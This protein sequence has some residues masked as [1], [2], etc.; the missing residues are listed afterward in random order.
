M[1]E[2]PIVECPRCGYEIR[3]AVPLA[4]IDPVV[5][6]GVKTQKDI[7]ELAE[8][9]ARLAAAEQRAEQAERERDAMRDWMRAANQFAWSHE[10]NCPRWT[11]ENGMCNCGLDTFLSRPR[12]FIDSWKSENAQLRAVVDAAREWNN[13]ARSSAHQKLRDALVAYDAVRKG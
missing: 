5:N 4:P 11:E 13:T 2:Y 6:Y 1:S 3:I 8:L 12:K 10:R 9:R 7:D